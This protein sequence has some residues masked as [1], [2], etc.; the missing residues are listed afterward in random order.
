MLSIEMSDMFYGFIRNY[1]GLGLRAGTSDAN[2]TREILGFYSRLG[3]MLGCYV[4]YE[5]KRF[6]LVWFWDL[7]AMNY[8]KPFL[9]IEHENRP[10]RLDH[11]IS[12]IKESMCESILII[13]YPDSKSEMTRF[14]EALA[15]LLKGMKKSVELLAILGSYSSVTTN[16][17]SQ[18]TYS[19]A[20]RGLLKNSVLEGRQPRTEYSMLSR[21]L[22]NAEF[23]V[24][25]D[26]Y[27][28]Q[29]NPRSR[30][31]FVQTRKTD[32]IRFYS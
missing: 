27:D 17:L 8:E 7:A 2:W 28:R 14:L 12:K 19:R 20:G 21:F 23:L 1:A 4:L 26:H 3:Q 18:D 24:W 5:W 16:T 9:H 30:I 15:S 6:D 22:R 29:R 10:N 11:L 13:A 32:V 25:D 31:P